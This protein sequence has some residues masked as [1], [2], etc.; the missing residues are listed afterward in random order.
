MIALAAAAPVTMTMTPAA[1]MIIPIFPITSL[2][3][4]LLPIDLP[5]RLSRCAPGRPA[6]GRPGGKVLAG[7]S[8]HRPGPAVLATVPDPSAA[9]APEPAARAS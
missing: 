8:F 5:V 9:R 4:I 1:S 6:H 2:N 7:V 3:T